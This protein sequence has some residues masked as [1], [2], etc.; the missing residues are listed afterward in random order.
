MH[1]DMMRTKSREMLHRELLMHIIANNLVR[2]L[3]IRKRL[4][5]A[6]LT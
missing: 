1:M 6:P 2:V 4:K 3:I 5:L